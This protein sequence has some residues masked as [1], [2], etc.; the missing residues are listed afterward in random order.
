MPCTMPYC[1]NGYVMNFSLT[2]S[3]GRTKPMSWLLTHTSALRT[4][5]FGTSVISTVPGCTT[6]PAVCVAMSLT[7]P[8]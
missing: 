8:S 4:S 6:V 1:W 7:T 5:P 3:P 2:G